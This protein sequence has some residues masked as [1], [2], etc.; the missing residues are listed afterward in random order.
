MADELTQRVADELEIRNLVNR[1]AQLA[2]DGELDEYVRCFTKDG[3]WD[4]GASIGVR[5]GHE[6][7][8]AGSAGRRSTGD[9]GPGSNTRH[10]I[11]TSTVDV[12]GDR[13]TGRAV[14]QHFVET[15][16]SPTLNMIGVYE[17]EFARTEGGWCLARRRVLMGPAIS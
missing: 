4:G 13:A 7:I 11:T 8:R 16:A 14:F 6:E 15:H 10:L 1:I 2:D 5:K 3:I 17:D 9:S 12:Q